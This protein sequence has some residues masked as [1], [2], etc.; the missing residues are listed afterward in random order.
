MSNDTPEDDVHR[1]LAEAEAALNAARE[2]EERYR[3]LF[4]SMGQGYCE[5]ELLRDETGRAVDQR[6]IAFNPAFERL[7]GIPIAEAEGRTAS[8]VFPGLEAWWHEAFDRIAHD[9]RPERIEHGVTSLGR[10]FEVHV[11]P[12]DRNHLTVLYEGLSRW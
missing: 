5:L 2:S 8:E 4:Q 9:G 12:T 3:S 1:R 7:F 10:A 11:Y 6:Y